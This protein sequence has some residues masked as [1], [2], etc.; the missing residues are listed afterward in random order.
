M[1]ARRL[2]SLEDLRRYL[3]NLINRVENKKVDPSL[4]GRLGYLANS[5]ARIIEGSELERR[6]NALERQILLNANA[7]R[8]D[9]RT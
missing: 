2:K 1:P 6:V 4:A 7:E 5:L 3:A 9:R 8:R